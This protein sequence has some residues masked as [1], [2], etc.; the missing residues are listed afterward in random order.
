MVTPGLRDECFRRKWRDS[1]TWPQNLPDRALISYLLFV[2]HKHLPEGLRQGENVS[3]RRILSA[4][5]RV[6]QALQQ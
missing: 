5:R 4:F 1:K 2:Q 3:Y 6:E